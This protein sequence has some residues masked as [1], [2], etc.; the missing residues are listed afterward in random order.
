MPQLVKG[1]KHVFGWS[2]LEK[3][4]RFRIPDEAFQEYGFYAD[5]RLFLLSGSKRS[6]GFG[7]TSLRLLGD[8]AIGKVI[9]NNK[10]LSDGLV[11]EGE[12]LLIGK[13]AYSWIR[14]AM[15]G[16]LKRPR[17]VQEFF[18]L[19]DKLLAVRGSGLALGFITK[20]PI[21]SGANSHS[22]LLVF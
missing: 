14:N 5:D 8:S 20:G 3:D 10:I 13:R 4:G 15:N 6:G 1:G 2:R 21:Y 12:I 19:P 18:N 22:E 7:L 17:S 9:K 16:E 11:P